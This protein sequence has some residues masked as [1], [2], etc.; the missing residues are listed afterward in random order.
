MPN[1]P[2]SVQLADQ[3]IGIELLS[4]PRASTQAACQALDDVLSELMF[5]SRLH[6]S[7]ER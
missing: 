7:G 6:S 3:T 4:A 5:C 1:F 2:S